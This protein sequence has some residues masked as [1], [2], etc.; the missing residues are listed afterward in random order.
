MHYYIQEKA[1][2][3]LKMKP[4]IYRKNDALGRP[5]PDLTEEELNL[6]KLG[7]RQ[8]I[9]GKGKTPDNPLVDIGIHGF[10]L[11]IDLFHF[12][13]SMQM[14]VKMNVEGVLDRMECEHIVTGEEL[15]LFNL[16]KKKERTS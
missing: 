7:C 15:V 2:L 1:R 4:E 13:L 5:E 3:F 10:Y 16:V 11:L 14:M 6:I 9:E 8:I 12:E